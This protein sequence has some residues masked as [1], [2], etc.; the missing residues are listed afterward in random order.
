MRRPSWG[1]Q[2][3][4]GY[5]AE[6]SALLQPQQQ[7]K[8]EEDGGGREQQ[9]P[10]QEQEHGEQQQHPAQQNTLQQQLQLQLH[11]LQLQLQQLRRQQQQQQLQRQHQEQLQQQEQQKIQQQPCSDQH[12][13]HS[14]QQYQQAPHQGHPDQEHQQQQQQQNQTAA[15]GLPR[16]QCLSSGPRGG[17]KH[18]TFSS[19]V[20]GKDV[21]SLLKELQGEAG[22][23]YGKPSYLLKTSRERS[24]LYGLLNP[25]VLLA[26]YKFVEEQRV[27]QLAAMKIAKAL[28]GEAPPARPLILAEHV[29]LL[30]TLAAYFHSTSCLSKVKAS[31]FCRRL[32]EPCITVLV[33]FGVSAESLGLG[34]LL[35]QAEQLE[36]RRGEPLWRRLR[37]GANNAEDSFEAEADLLAREAAGKLYSKELGLLKQ[38][39]Q[40]TEQQRAAAVAAAAG[41][42]AAA[43]AAATAATGRID[44]FLSWEKVWALLV[45]KT[46]P[47]HRK[48]R[49]RFLHAA[50]DWLLRLLLPLWDDFR[51]GPLPQ[52]LRDVYHPRFCVTTAIFDKIGRLQQQA[53]AL[54]AA[55]YS[56]DES[57]PAAPA[58]A[59]AAAGVPLGIGGGALAGAENI[60]QRQQQQQ[61]RRKNSGDGGAAERKAGAGTEDGGC[62][63]VDPWGTSSHGTD[64]FFLD[65]ILLRKRSAFK[66]GLMSLKEEKEKNG[67]DENAR[68][69]VCVQ[70]GGV[71][72]D[73]ENPFYALTVA[74]MRGMELSNIMNA[75]IVSL[76]GFLLDEPLL[77]HL[78]HFQFNCAP[79]LSPM[80]SASFEDVAPDAFECARELAGISDQDYRKSLCSTDFSFI[81][82]HKSGQFF[83]FSHDGKFLIKTISKAEVSQIL[84]FLPAYIDHI[85]TTPL[86]LLT[87][88]FGIHRVELYSEE[89]VG[90]SGGPPEAG[91]WVSPPATSEGPFSPPCRGA[92][93]R[94]KLRVP[95]RGETCSNR[96]APGNLLLDA[97][98]GSSGW[99][100]GMTSKGE[101]REQESAVAACESWRDA[102]W[103]GPPAAAAASRGP[104]GPSARGHCLSHVRSCSSMKGPP[105]S[106]LTSFA[107]KHLK[108]RSS[109][110]Q[111]QRQPTRSPQKDAAGL[112]VAGADSMRGLPQGSCGTS[113]PGSVK[114]GGPL[115]VPHPQG[116]LNS[117][118]GQNAAALRMATGARG[119]LKQRARGA[120]SATSQPTAYSQAPDRRALP[121]P[122]CDQR[123]KQ[124]QQQQQQKPELDMSHTSSPPKSGLLTTLRQKKNP[125]ATVS[126]AADFGVL[127]GTAFDPS[128]GLS[129]AYDIKGSTVGRVAQASDRVKKDVDWLESGRRLRMREDEAQILLAAHE[130]DCKFL[131]ELGIFDYSLL[132]GIH[133]CL[134][135]EAEASENTGVLES[136]G[137]LR[138]YT[139]RAHMSLEAAVVLDTG[140]EAPVYADAQQQQQQQEQQPAADGELFRDSSSLAGGTCAPAA[141]AA[142]AASSV[143]SAGGISLSFERDSGQ[144]LESTPGNS[145]VSP[146]EDPAAAAAAG[147]AKTAA[148]AAATAAGVA[149]GSPGEGGAQ[150]V[151]SLP[152]P[153]GE[154]GKEESCRLGVHQMTLGSPVSVGSLGAASSEAS[155]PDGEEQA[156]GA[157]QQ[158][159]GKLFSEVPV[160]ASSAPSK[161][162]A[163]AATAAAAAAEADAREEGLQHFASPYKHHQSSTDQQQEQQEG[164]Q[165]EE[166]EQQQQQHELHEQQQQQDEAGDE[167]GQ[168]GA[169]AAADCSNGARRS[170]SPSLQQHRIRFLASGSG[171]CKSRGTGGE[172]SQRRRS[173]N[174]KGLDECSDVTTTRTVYF[175][176]GQSI[177]SSR[178]HTQ[179]STPYLGAPGL[180][181]GFG[182]K[183][184]SADRREVY[185]FGLIDFLCP[186][187]AA[188]YLHTAYKGF[189]CQFGQISP[190]PPGYYS[191]RQISFIRKH[192]VEAAPEAAKPDASEQT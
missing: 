101:I 95:P 55:V 158:G 17:A 51:E 37:L 79:V 26:F 146:A 11:Q 60:P 132:V 172:T 7:Q 170:C 38:Q 21:V 71:A 43:A 97:S 4:C 39:Q 77:L 165:E 125:Y 147:A 119:A 159:S 99:L 141:A 68:F 52:L 28:M 16:W 137:P 192:V 70:F 58:A 56:Q 138:D 3:P 160:P 128:L 46:G 88:L 90:E 150:E 183:V 187:T 67:G 190:V 124:Q 19:I 41:A 9:A 164:E 112:L 83:F 82:Y 155:F 54:A 27:K 168:R 139:T 117:L 89:V 123:I 62:T 1:P 189:N 116:A 115:W 179:M 127:S 64:S 152:P 53:A 182:V 33:Y 65:T 14:N 25:V 173:R 36:V 72:V 93:N 63:P 174:G 59:A 42:A 73:T 81:E 32:L 178:S 156:A 100:C 162:P 10:Q 44:Q 98:A 78:R 66:M 49:H 120:I 180:E 15:A 20:A 5:A 110:K 145:D 107:R 161:H 186:Y 24:L 144:Q 154:T 140:S 47:G 131:A 34:S 121:C 69:R 130:R 177:L 185:F 2:P 166:E 50:A 134:H 40:H 23:D 118:M 96:G 45:Q 105:R 163:P 142:E 109:K 31:Y 12:S 85:L 149:I 106:T 151:L 8:E 102:A 135:K 91:G 76:L 153:R 188:R 143:A 176:Y 171:S 114:A 6:G 136:Q 94:K 104:C 74:M 61:Q 122:C 13:S 111:Q 133:E 191:R 169:P 35:Q 87:R 48:A 108:S 157:L 86:S 29:Y 57:A 181:G 126:A 92:C 80:Y 30:H 129:E 148:A 167:G 84:R 113:R 103:V 22:C 175:P 75:G 18:A 184:M